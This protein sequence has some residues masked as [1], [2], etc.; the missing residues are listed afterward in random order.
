MIAPKTNINVRT[1]LVAGGIAVGDRTTPFYAGAFHYWRVDPSR[2]TACLRAMHGM[3][4]TV[5]ES[6][7]P[8]REHELDDG[9][10]VGLE[11]VDERRAVPELLGGDLELVGDDFLDLGLDVLIVV[12]HDYLVRC[13][14]LIVHFPAHIN[15]EPVRP[16]WPPE[17]RGPASASLRFADRR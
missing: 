2:W 5:V 6:Y 9:Q 14:A 15:R 4:F 17:R 12:S 10:R 3:G 7:V 11:V 16:I 13:R 1:E 8:W